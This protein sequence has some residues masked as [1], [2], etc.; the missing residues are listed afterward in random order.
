MLS[1]I[2]VATCV[3]NGLV[4]KKMRIYNVNETGISLSRVN[5]CVRVRFVEGIL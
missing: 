5:K 2:S 4:L 3:L 1:Y